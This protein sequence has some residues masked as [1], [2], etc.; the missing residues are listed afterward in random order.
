MAEARWDA[1][2]IMEFQ[3]R[4]D[5]LMT[6]AG[7]QGVPDV[8]REAVLRAWVA[9]MDGLRLAGP[10]LNTLQLMGFTLPKLEQEKNNG[11]H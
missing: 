3:Q 11:P 4:F 5:E 9:K 8:F 2:S 10:I 7:Q 1:K 6:W